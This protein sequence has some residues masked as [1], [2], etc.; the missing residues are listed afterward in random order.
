MGVR[1]RVLD[2]QR[3]SLHDG[4]GIRTAVFL[5][6]CP[7][8]CLW[9]HNPES[10]SP[11]PQLA[12][13]AERCV[14]CGECASACPRQ[15]HRVADGRHELDRASCDACGQCADA[16]AFD[17][18]RLVGREWDEAEVL[19][20]V[21]RDRSY[22]LASGGGL[23]ITGGEPLVQ[24]EFTRAVL[25]G[26]RQ[27]GIHTCVET[28]GAAPWASFDAIRR[29]VDLF[30]F[31][32]KAT[33]EAE[34]RRLTGA[35]LSPILANLE[36]LLAGGAAVHLRCPLVPGLNDGQTHLEA[37]AT[38]ARRH[39]GLAVEVLPFHDTARH[40]H[41]RYGSVDPLPALGSA[42]EDDRRRWCDTL[43]A[44]GCARVVDGGG[45]PSRRH[46]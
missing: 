14:S 46:P 16:C 20:L 19:E 38:L 43:R 12:F 31:D 24:V 9:C 29:L 15:L 34:H 40:K 26:A 42:G 22:Y 18:L 2:V 30:L 4:P 1:G 35:P 6:S 36:R 25:E 7:L 28:C 32:L 10:R 13:F 37:V 41:A 45:A 33:G 5:K 17:A 39:P 11:R 3:F 27:R 21:E 23:T 8:R 44:L